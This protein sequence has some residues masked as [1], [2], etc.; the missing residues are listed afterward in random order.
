[1]TGDRSMKGEGTDLVARLARTAAPLVQASGLKALSAER[2][3][4]TAGAASVEE[5]ATT[6]G[7]IPFRVALLAELF[8]RARAT[9]I[10]ATANLEPGIDRLC[11]AFE[12]Y[13]DYNLAHPALQALAHE[14][15][16]TQD[17]WNALERMAGGVTLVAQAELNVTRWPQP[18]ETARLFTAMCVEVVKLE[19]RSGR[20]L[21]ELRHVLF[22]LC[23][24]RPE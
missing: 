9:V 5:V 2:L 13:L 19:Y 8:G 11:R 16:A 12:A 6:L 7:Q 20:A 3:Q 18:P 21:P 14:L 23:R 15:Y 4:A 17:G 10:E 22:S 1:M 24:H